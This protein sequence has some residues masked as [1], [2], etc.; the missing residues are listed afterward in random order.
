MLARFLERRLPVRRGERL[1]LTRG[2]RRFFAR[3]GID[4][5]G[6]ARFSEAGERKLVAWFTHRHGAM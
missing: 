4:I 3:N 5:D 1:S 2:G 6:L